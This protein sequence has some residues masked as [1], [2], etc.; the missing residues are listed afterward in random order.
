MRDATQARLVDHAAVHA[1]S[2]ILSLVGVTWGSARLDAVRVVDDVFHRIGTSAP[3]SRTLAVPVYGG[4]LGSLENLVEEVH[5]A[6]RAWGL[7]RDQARAL[8]RHHGTRYGEVFD[9]VHQD[10]SLA[11]SLPGTRVL[12]AEV[13]HAVRMEMAQSLED[14][15]YRRTDLRLEGLPEPALE[16]AAYL[17]GKELGWN[18]ERTRQEVAQVSSSPPARTVSVPEYAQP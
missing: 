4:D 12:R 11:G 14:L 6:A 18:A 17:M 8:A 7:T 16:E 15:V 13:V 5:E 1:T 9:L 2:G 10:P 3:P